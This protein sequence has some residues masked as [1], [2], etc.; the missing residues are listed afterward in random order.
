MNLSSY[1]GALKPVS[2]SGLDITPN[3]KLSPHFHESTRSRLFNLSMSS[4]AVR[5][6]TRMENIFTCCAGL[7][8]HKESVETC[9]RR[10]ESSGRVHSET[11]HWGT[12]T[13]DLQAM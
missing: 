5:K 8:V 13:Q 3:P 10:I 12:M 6:E 9:V 1:L 7:D 2:K 4:C 11:R